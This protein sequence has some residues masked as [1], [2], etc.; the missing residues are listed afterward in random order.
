VGAVSGVPEL[1]ANCTMITEDNEDGT[2]SV[3]I[4]ISPGTV[5]I[6]R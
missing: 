4:R 5:V 1:P 2:V 6:I 3:K